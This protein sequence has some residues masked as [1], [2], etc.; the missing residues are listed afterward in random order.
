[1]RP[2]R[3]MAIGLIPLLGISSCQPSPPTAEEIV[4]RCADAMSAGARVTDI[5]TLRLA[6]LYPDHPYPVHVE[7]ARPNK[8]RSEAGENFVLV[9][10]GKRAAF[11]LGGPGGKGPELVPEEEW[12]DFE[13][14]VA[15][16]FPAFFEYPATYLGLIDTAGF[17]AHK[18]E[19]VLPAGGKMTYYLDPATYL[20]SET[21]TNVTIR[22]EEYSWGRRWLDYQEISG[23]LYFKTFEYK[24]RNG[25]ETGTFQTVEVNAPIDTARF[26][27]PDDIR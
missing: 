2:I 13:V 4:S 27:I 6:S 3:V 10:D 7:I 26:S 12:K 5:T 14:D 18:L 21:V 19:V 11:L 9:F 1:M 8:I 16:H 25:I 24:G 23:V 20:I 17:R 22:G 15:F